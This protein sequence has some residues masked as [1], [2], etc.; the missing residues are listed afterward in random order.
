MRWQWVVGILLAVVAAFL[1]ARDLRRA[2]SDRLRR[3]VT[4]LVASLIVVVL[5]GTFGGRSVP[6]PGW[7]ALP[8]AV[9]A[10]EAARGWR[11]TRRGHLWEAGIGAWAVALALAAV[12]LATAGEHFVTLLCGAVAMAA[13]GAGLMLRSRGHEARPWRDEDHDHYERR[14]VVRPP[15]P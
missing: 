4:L 11:S 14:D 13:L 12:A 3:P 2:G 7:L 10:W 15:A 8:A 9:L 5:A 1:L 6:H